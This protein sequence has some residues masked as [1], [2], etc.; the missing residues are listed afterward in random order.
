MNPILVSPPIQKSTKILLLVT[1]HRDQ[2]K[3]HET[4]RNLLEKYVPDCTYSPFT[5]II[6]MLSSP[7]NHIYAILLP[8]PRILWNSSQSYLRC[9]LPACSLHSAP[10]KTTHNSH[11]VLF[12]S[13]PTVSW[14]TWQMRTVTQLPGSMERLLQAGSDCPAPPDLPKLRAL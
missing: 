4:S 1:I 11:F 12:F 7:Q 9:C 10:N 6:Y 14:P 2:Q 5:K 13:K 8:A 3:L